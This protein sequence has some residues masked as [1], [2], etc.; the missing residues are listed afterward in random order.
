MTPPSTGGHSS[1]GT[2]LDGGTGASIGVLSSARTSP[3][4]GTETSN[5]NLLGRNNRGRSHG[6]GNNINTV[7]EALHA[8]VS[9]NRTLLLLGNSTL[10]RSHASTSTSFNRNLLNHGVVNKNGLSI[11]LKKK[12]DE[13][14]KRV[15]EP[16]KV[17]NICINEE[18]KVG[19]EIS[20]SLELI[21][22]N[23]SSNESVL[24]M[25][26]LPK[27]RKII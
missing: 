23:E 15:T 1:I 14:K 21:K 20:L 7:K 9:S 26:G 13:I 18:H 27:K 8:S 3:N 5:R 24:F 19:I 25:L 12:I 2:S 4:R 6:L 17:I 16:K 22:Q 10:G 11:N